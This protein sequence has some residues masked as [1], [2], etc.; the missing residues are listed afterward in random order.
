MVKHFAIIW[1]RIVGT[2]EEDMYKI[3]GVCIMFSSLL[4]LIS[5]TYWY[6][7]MPIIISLGWIIFGIGDILE[8][9]AKQYPPSNK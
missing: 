3:I 4:T 6:I 8:K 2:E 7:Y 9:I 1:Y 5:P